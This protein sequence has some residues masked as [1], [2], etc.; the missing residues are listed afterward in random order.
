MPVNVS[1]LARTAQRVN[2]AAL[3]ELVP[4]LGMGSG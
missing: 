3:A 4:P 2:L 1:E